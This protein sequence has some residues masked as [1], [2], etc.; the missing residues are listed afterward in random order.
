MRYKTSRTF[1][2]S[3]LA[4]S[5]CLVCAHCG[6]P[7]AG[8]WTNSTAPSA[9]SDQYSAYKTTLTYGDGMTVSV[10]LETTRRMGA[11]VF[12]GCAES[13]TGMGTYVEANNTITC[14]F[15]SASTTRMGCTYMMDNSMSTTLDDQTKALLVGLSSGSFVIANDMLNLTPSGGAKLTYAKQAQ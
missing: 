9:A 1:A 3:F 6:D 14:T 5:L 13:I 4:T 11:L 10:D 15:A 12:A 2:R 7:A 8:T